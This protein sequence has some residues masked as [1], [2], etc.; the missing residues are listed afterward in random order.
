MAK[1]DGKTTLEKHILDCKTVAEYYWDNNLKIMKNWCDRINCDFDDFKHNLKIAIHY[2][3]FGKATKKWQEE[4]RKEIPSLPPHAPYA[5]FF[6]ALETK[7]LAPILATISHHSLL[8]NGTGNK[9]NSYLKAQ[10]Y[11]EELINFN[12]SLGFNDKIDFN[13]LPNYFLYFNKKIVKMKRKHWTSREYPINVY[14]KALYCNLLFLLTSADVF[15]SKFESSE[16]INIISHIN[17]DLPDYESINSAFQ[18]IDQNKIPFFTQRQV[19]KKLEEKSNANHFV[20][21][22][23]CGEGKTLSSL[24]FAR[25]LWKKHKLNRIIYTLPTQTTTNNMLKEFSEEYNIP[26]QWIGLYHSEVFNFLQTQYEEQKS[27]LKSKIFLDSFYIRPFN[28]STIDHLLLSLVNGY[29]YAPRAFGAL[30][31]S[32]VIIDEMHYYDPHTIGMI[33]CLC[34]ILRELKI[35]YFIMSATIPNIIKEKFLTDAIHYTSSGLDEDNHEK[36]PYKIEYHNTRT[37]DNEIVNSDVSTIIDENAKK[38]ICIVVN[39]VK[40]AKSLYNFLIQKYPDDQLL[41]YHSQF[42][43]IDRPKK[44][45]LLNIWMAV[46]KSNRKLTDEENRLCEECNFDPFKRLIFVGTQVIEIS[47]NLSFDVM[48]ADLAPLDALFQRAGRLHRNQSFYNSNNCNCWQCMKKDETHHYV[49]HVFDTGEDYPPYYSANRKNDV[50]RQFN[51]RIFENTKAA[52]KKGGV[53]SFKWGQ[54]KLNSVYDNPEMLE[55][56]DGEASFWSKFRD[57][58]IF[59]E[60]PFDNKED[61]NP[62]IKTRN[63]DDNRQEVLPQIFR[64]KKV[65]IT[66]DEFLNNL[67]HDSYFFRDGKFTGNGYEEISK[68]TLKIYYGEFERIMTEDSIII[69][70]ASYDFERGLSIIETFM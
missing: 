63:I 3:D 58:M 42:T 48:M 62:R 22:A 67:K 68:Y 38:S 64:L 15:A 18:N 55:L 35:P 1:S 32:L 33:N 39:T 2:H 59:G 4:A 53:Y 13:Q 29:K 47:L 40:R 30:Q 51:K 17:T 56:F 46:N 60:K 11:Q 69:A 34:E 6:M 16:D 10:F 23:P 70:K 9:Y 28:I 54:E 8:T 19:I 26:E 21:E 24:L 5:G 25:E 65:Q 7:E 20:L 50:Y 44:E 66:A 41:L 14:F 57:D 45:K 43:R 12:R 36:H 49:F 31:T 61:L 27:E 52:I 37:I